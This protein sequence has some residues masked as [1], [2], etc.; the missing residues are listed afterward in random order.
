[1]EN[2]RKKGIFSEDKGKSDF[3][4]H[5]ACTCVEESEH[6]NMQKVKNR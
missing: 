4:E 2:K 5:C 3:A 6:C 1:M